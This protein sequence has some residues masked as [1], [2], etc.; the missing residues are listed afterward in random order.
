MTEFLKPDQIDDEW[1]AMLLDIPGYD[2]IKSSGG[3]VFDPV[4]AD[5]ALRF[6]PGALRH[7]EGEIAG[8]PF[9]LEHWQKAIVANLFGWKK[10]DVKGRWVRRYREVMIYVARKNGKM[11]ALDTPLPTPTG[12]TTM[13]EVQ[14]GDVLFDENGEHCRVIGLSDIDLAPES[15]KVTFSNGEQIRACADH[16]WVTT[17]RVDAV[18]AG[19]GQRQRLFRGMARGSRV[20]KMTGIRT[21]SEIFDTQ[22]HGARG[23]RNHSLQMPLPLNTEE[24]HLPIDPYVLGV[25]LGDGDSDCARITCGIVDATEMCRNLLECG[26]ETHQRQKYRKAHRYILGGASR[27]QQARNSS[28]QAGLRK[29]GVLCA[30]HIPREYLRASFNQRVSLLQGLMDTDGTVDKRGRR[31]EYVSS[32]KRL[33]EDVSELLSSL[34]IKFSWREKLPRCNGRLL[35]EPVHILQFMAFADDLPVFR[36]SRKLARM[37][38]RDDCKVSPRSRSVQISAV[39]RCSPTPMRCI[40]VDSQSHQYLCGRTMLPTHNSP[41]ASG[42]ALLVFFMD[43]MVGKQCYLAAADREQASVVF[44]HCKGMVQQNQKLDKLCRIYG[45]SNTSYNSR[46]I[47]V[48]EEASFLRVI[49]ADADSKH[50]GNTCLA[51]ID[52]L[53]AQPNGELVDVLTTSMASANV[54]QPLLVYLTTADYNRESICNTKHKYACGVRDGKINDAAFLPVLYESTKEDDWTDPEVWKR[55]NP[56]YGISVSE[57]YLA[58]ECERAKVEPSYQNTFKRLH[59]NIQTESVEAWFRMDQWDECGADV[60]TE[61]LLRNNDCF[62]G[63]D[64]SST[65]DITAFVLYFPDGGYVLSYFWL[66]GETAEERQRKD[67]VPYTEWTGAGLIQETDKNHIDDDAIFDKIC[68]LGLKFNIRQIAFDGWQAASMFNRLAKHGF[69]AVKF[70]QSVNMMN[71]PSKRL[72]SMLANREIRHGGNPVLRWMATNTVKEQDN[73]GFIRPSKKHSSEKIDGIAALIMAIGAADAGEPVE[74]F[75]YEIW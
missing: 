66:P 7:V 34:G 61:E 68:E 69:D 42:I 36:L 13:G 37:R 25:W 31:L 35:D 55:A 20:A 41:L 57:E 33:A 12:W 4:A 63:L 56:N 21:T 59:L 15:Y 75:E 32:D 67:G 74:K 43:Q 52:E 23:D 10:Q 9:V 22:T 72:E 17:V 6:F 48:E 60:V 70:P 24:A 50:G 71:S 62:A 1:R 47:V 54:P 65:K 19:C 30:K 2:A 29:L 16:Q 26:V 53:H 49:S 39:E 14:V 64:L 11:L 73:K 18:G 46:S 40:E 5:E 27:T 28:I 3:A 51:I 44:R 45:G 38:R 58:R 8:Q